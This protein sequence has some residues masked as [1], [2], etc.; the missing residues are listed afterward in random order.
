MTEENY[1]EHHLDYRPPLSAIDLGKVVY[2]GT[3]AEIYNYARDEYMRSIGYPYSKFLNEDKKN[4]AVI[5]MN[6][7][8][9]KPL[10][11]DEETVIVSKV[12]K[13]GTKS[14]VFD[15]KIYKENM[16]ILCNEAKFVMVC[17]GLSFKAEK[18]PE[19][20]KNAFKNGPAV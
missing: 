18:I 16:Q 12:E 8:F 9:R 2:N 6:V 15:Q 19:V 11:Y 20:L 13:I 14:I 3:Y 5:E 7:K 17:I 4:F 10:H 1:P